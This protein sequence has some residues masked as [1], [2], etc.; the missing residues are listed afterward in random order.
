MKDVIFILKEQISWFKVELTA[1][2]LVNLLSF[3][4]IK[5]LPI[6]EIFA[7]LILLSAFVISIT[8][9]MMSRILP[10]TNEDINCPSIKYYLSLPISKRS[11]MTALTL[12]NVISFLP[13]VL[14]SLLLGGI[15]V[16]ALE[17]KGWN[18]LLFNSYA[19]AFLAII[20]SASVSHLVTR[21][22]S[23]YQQIDSKLKMYLMI[24][25]LVM[26]TFYL[27]AS[28]YLNIIYSFYFQV[29][30]KKYFLL[31]E[32]IFK[33]I[34]LTV[35]FIAESYLGP[36]LIL[37]LTAVHLYNVPKI[38]K[39]ESK[40]AINPKFYEVFDFKK[41]IAFC[42]IVIIVPPFFK[43]IRDGITLEALKPYYNYHSDIGKTVAH[44]DFELVKQNKVDD[45]LAFRS[46]SN[47]NL[48]E[49]AIRYNQ[50][51]ILKF[52]DSLSFPVEE[53][54]LIKFAFNNGNASFD[55]IVKNHWH[56]KKKPYVSVNTD[57][58]DIL[59]YVTDFT[60]QKCNLLLMKYLIES[61]KVDINLG[62]PLH[63]AV[64]KNCLPIV[65]YLKERGIELNI[66]DQ[67]GRTALVLAEELNQKKK[68]D[69]LILEYLKL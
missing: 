58:E 62:T 42:L 64:R 49:I 5:V 65:V 56:D 48:Y 45:L 47:L 33:Y 7:I 41:T 60:S 8:L 19:I 40:G 30:P 27:F 38:F 25:F 14:F 10:S 68:I 57:R 39:T 67:N 35:D 61:E 16:S 54:S 12:S 17:I 37:L 26:V 4:I 13:L 28:A 3:I 43:P 59:Y 66:R 69:N 50:I 24:R 44:G 52:L 55:Y 23:Q 36:S 53:D 34:T 32:I 46:S 18:L 22:R 15:S 21:P 9:S 11:M 51:E 29:E 2:V 1:G 31:F 20:S 63:M 6:P